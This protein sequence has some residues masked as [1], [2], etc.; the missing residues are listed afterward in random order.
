M[1]PPL[2]T[3]HPPQPE[4]LSLNLSRDSE[5]LVVKVEKIF[6]T[7]LRDN[8][9]LGFSIAGGLGATPY[10]EGCESLFVSKLSEGGTAAKDGKLRVGDKILQINGVDVTDARHDQAVQMLTRLERFVRL[11]VER[12]SLVPR[13]SAPN[14]LNTSS[15]KSPKVF[16]VPK[17]Y[18]GLYSASSYMANRPSYGLRSRE[19][20][21]YTLGGA[22]SNYKLPGLAGIPGSESTSALARRSSSTLP[23]SDLSSDQFDE[24]IP[25]GIRTK[26]HQSTNGL[27]SG[28]SSKPGIVTESIVKTP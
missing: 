6:T 22:G 5:D 11:V 19:P 2:T 4:S 23:G 25:H 9:G 10:R 3:P 7:L 20:G 26:L 18:T 16:G 12:E 28:V 13:S 8:S 15:E 24:M 14:S 27:D 17:P 1:P 21:N